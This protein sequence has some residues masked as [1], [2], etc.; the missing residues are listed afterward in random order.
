[1]RL[2]IALGGNALLKRGE[3]L[4]A[5]N[6]TRNMQAAAKSLARVCDGNEVALVHGNGPQVGLLSLEAEAYPDVPPYPFD[7][8]GAESQ[9]MIGYVIAQA[10]RNARPAR[11]IAALLTRVRVDPKDPAFARPTKPIGPVYDAHQTDTL[12]A[13]R[14]WSFAADGNGMRRVIASPRPVDIIELQVIERLVAAG[15]VTVCAGGGGIPVRMLPDGALDGVEAVIDKDLTA[16]LL[17]QRLKAERLVILTDVDAVYLDWHAPGRR[18]LRRI[19][20]ADL[21]RHR[22]AEGSMAPKVEAACEFV[23]ASGRPAVIGALSQA[24]SVLAGETG[25]E[26]L[27]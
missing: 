17:A 27:P 16:A 24:H 6:Q 10:L 15:V 19:C 21:Q 14:D 13:A 9:G 2:V 26:V 22:F 12:R 8:L 1:M 3:P 5:E 20:V 4:T 25:T 7:L 11:E 23:L 18:P